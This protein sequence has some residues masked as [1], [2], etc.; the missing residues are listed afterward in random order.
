MQITANV[1][2]KDA[3]CRKI[4][5]RPHYHIAGTFKCLGEPMRILLPTLLLCLLAPAAVVLAQDKPATALAQDNPLSATN[6]RFYGGM[7]SMLLLSAQ[8]VPEEYYSFKPTEAVRSYGQIIG[9]M[10][11]SHYGFCSLVLGEKGPALRIEQTKTSKA[12]LIAALKEAFS[13]CDKAYNS[14]TDASAI[15]MVSFRGKDTPKLGVFTAYMAHSGLH[16][17]N[18]VTYMRLK[19]IVPPTS[20]PGF[21]EPP[22]K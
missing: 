4:S 3:G 7:K 20:E 6:R 9:H 10:A 2:K 1:T 12:D 17:G 11:D 19:N 14:M 5:A 21:L 8:K 16:Y 18:L 22:K 13:Y 15:Q